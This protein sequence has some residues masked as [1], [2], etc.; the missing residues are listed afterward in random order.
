[1]EA[2]I[3]FEPMNRG[4]AD[5]SLNHLGTPPRMGHRNQ[6]AVEASTATAGASIMRCRAGLCE[7]AP[8]LAQSAQKRLAGTKKPADLS[9]AP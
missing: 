3:G 2:A 9:Q 5:L 1:M 8:A 7:V 4:F 6:P